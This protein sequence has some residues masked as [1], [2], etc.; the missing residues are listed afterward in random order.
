MILMAKGK[1]S[2]Q[3]WSDVKAAMADMD[4]KQLIALVSDLYRLSRENQAFLHARLGIGDDTLGPY[5][6]TISDCMY[7]DAYKNKPVQI[8]K[9]KKAISSYIKA[10]G[11]PSGEAELMTFFVECGNS[12]TVDFGDIDEAFYDALIRMYRRAIDK[13]LTL[14]EEEQ[15]EFQ[16]RLGAIMTSSSNIG[17]GYHDA[18]CDDYCDAFAEEECGEE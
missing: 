15:A 12:F 7:P 13:V 3:T 1:H 11:E 6:K 18:L 4:E 16:S 2:N 8:S 9:A 10:V 17:W 14:P 5:K